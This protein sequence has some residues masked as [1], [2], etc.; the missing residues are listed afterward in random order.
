MTALCAVQSAFS[1]A[2]RLLRARRMFSLFSRKGAAKSRDSEGCAL[3]L[4]YLRALHEFELQAFT[5]YS[6]GLL[7]KS[8]R[9]HLSCESAH[10]QIECANPK[11]RFWNAQKL[12]NKKL[13]KPKSHFWLF[14]PI[15]RR[16]T[17]RV[18]PRE[19]WWRAPKGRAARGKPFGFPLKIS[20]FRRHQLAEKCENLF[21]CLLYTSPS[22][23][24]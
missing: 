1:S 24:D 16:L 20:A 22:P 9:L 5:C 17:E 3:G 6:V 7:I 18:K 4:Q 13:K 19:S 8:R 12:F 11:L 14:P 21:I 10:A 23:R 15:C 2:A